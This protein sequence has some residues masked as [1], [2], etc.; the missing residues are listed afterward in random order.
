M[1]STS[2]TVVFGVDHGYE[3][4]KTA[5]AI[6]KSGVMAFDAEPLFTHNMLV[7]EDRHYIIGEGH[8][9]FAANKANDQDYYILTLAA[10][11]IELHICRLTSARVRFSAGHPLTWVGER[12]VACMACLLRN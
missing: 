12:N 11:G 5:H 7:Y 10:V 4:I 6:F 2:N 9:D 1:K 3:N 8:K